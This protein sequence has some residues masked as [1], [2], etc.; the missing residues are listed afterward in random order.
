MRQPRP[1]SSSIPRASFD[2]NPRAHTGR[3]ELF[4]RFRPFCHGDFNPR[5][6]TGRDMSQGPGIH[7][8]HISIHAPA[9][10]ATSPTPETF[11][12]AGISIHAPAWGATG[13]V[14]VACAVIDISIHAPAWGA[15]RT[16]KRAQQQ[17]RFQSTRPRGARP[18]PTN[19]IASPFLFQSTR[20]RGARR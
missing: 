8:T 3:D 11:N 14:Q 15:T 5:A 9:W 4:I 13:S 19:W 18:P 7:R 1:F 10:G 2:F 6:H 20:P 17:S 16:R 12:F